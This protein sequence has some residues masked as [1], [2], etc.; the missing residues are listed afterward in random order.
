[1]TNKAL[2]KLYVEVEKMK[3]KFEPFLGIPAKEI[4]KCYPIEKTCNKVLSKVLFLIKKHM[5]E[6][7][8]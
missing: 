3:F 7:K 2:S 5:E 8:K 4:E 6:G 1:M